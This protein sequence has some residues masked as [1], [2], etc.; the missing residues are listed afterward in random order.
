MPSKLCIPAIPW[1]VRWGGCYSS[2]ALCRSW[3]L[4]LSSG[5]SH[6]SITFVHLLDCRVVRDICQVV[7]EI[8]TI[9]PEAFVL[10]SMC[11][12]ECWR[13]R[14][15]VFRPSI[16]APVLFT[17]FS[18][19]SKWCRAAGALLCLLGVLSLKPGLLK[20]HF[21]KQESSRGHS[22]AESACCHFPFVLTSCKM[23][24]TYLI[25][26]ISR[27]LLWRT[28]ILWGCVVRIVERESFI[29]AKKSSFQEMSSFQNSV[30]FLIEG[31]LVDECD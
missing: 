4:G 16:S 18:V 10:T 3:V 19:P 9:F 13:A 7:W 31:E 28:L 30:L 25:D 23:C 6:C 26:I 27:I 11:V 14:T 22:T 20:V 5:Y 29:K 24:V 12:C 8:L 1:P 15:G 2:P 17:S 21:C